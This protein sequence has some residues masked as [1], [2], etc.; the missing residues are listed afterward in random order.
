MWKYFL[1]IGLTLTSCKSDTTKPVETVKPSASSKQFTVSAEA[2]EE[3]ARLDDCMNL[4][5]TEADIRSVI[6]QSKSVD[7]PEWHDRHIYPPCQL[8]GQI[9]YADA[10][11]SYAY[12]PTGYLKLE[13]QGEWFVCFDCSVNPDWV[14]FDEPSGG[15]VKRNSTNQ[16]LESSSVQ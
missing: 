6:A 10:V 5:V 16:N 3:S 9:E 1:L 7:G 8:T 11:V 15:L 4:N 14:E 12:S 13:G 2:L